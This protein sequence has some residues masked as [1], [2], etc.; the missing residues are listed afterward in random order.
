MKL[1][2]VMTELE[3]Y[4]SEQ[5]KNIA[6]KHGVKEPL[7]GVRVQDMKKIVKKVKKNYE[8]SVQLYNTGNSDAMYLAGLIADETKMTKADLQ[9]WVQGASNHGISQYTVPWIAAES[10]FGYELG[11]EWIESDSELI[12]TSGWCSLA[13]HASLTSDSELDI[14]QYANLLKRIEKTIHTSPNRVRYNMNGFVIAIGS[15]ITELNKQALEVAG[16]IG[17]VTV[18]MG[19]TSCKVPY[20]PDYIKK[21][22]DKGKLGKK[23][24]KARC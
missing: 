19:D 20:A 3:S 16:K 17:K 22:M 14:K 7:F 10:N 11:L 5:I 24:K 4:G 8:L 9:K 2:E 6:L 12:A 13:Y 1:K 21:V 15:Y 18:Y 23:K